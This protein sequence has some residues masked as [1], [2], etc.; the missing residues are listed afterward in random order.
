MDPHSEVEVK[1]DAQ[2]V[3]LAEYQN[4]VESTIP[5]L[6]GDVKIT[7]YKAVFGTDTYYVVNGHPLRFREGG[8]KESELTYKK[9]K[10]AGS[11][12]DRVEINVPL[13]TGASRE[14]V[15]AML[16]ALGGELDFTI[17]KWSYIY[18]VEGV[19][20]GTAYKATLALYDV[21]DYKKTSRRFLEV[22]IEA[23]SDCTPE[24]GLEVLDSWTRLVE[25]QLNVEGPLNESLY[26]IYTTKR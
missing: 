23:V 4:F 15:L 24:Q 8:D 25:D 20:A 18:H 10:S 17:D 14:A 2:D 11:I 22:E 21:E 16:E 1:F 3:P 13:K 6:I 19:L 12:S 9:R 7:G 26:E 5:A